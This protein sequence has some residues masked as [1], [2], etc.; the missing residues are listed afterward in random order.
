MHQLLQKK[1]LQSLLQVLKLLVLI[2][3]LQ[4]GN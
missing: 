3:Q 2:S 1:L 4:L